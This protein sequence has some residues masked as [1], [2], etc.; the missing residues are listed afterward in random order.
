MGE[1]REEGGSGADV[2]KSDQRPAPE[3]PPDSCS[4]TPQTDTGESVQSVVVL[5]TGCSGGGASITQNATPHAHIH[6]CDR[7][8]HTHSK[9]VRYVSE[10][11]CQYL[12]GC[13]SVRSTTPSCPLPSVWAS[14]LHNSL[15]FSVSGWPQ[16]IHCFTAHTRDGS[17]WRSTALYNSF[18]PHKDFLLLVLDAFTV[19]FFSSRLVFFVFV[20]P[21]R[22]QN[23]ISA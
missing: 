23:T 10:H 14:A 1:A 18:R 13:A 21:A 19:Y 9:A 8:K 7:H 3:F 15:F 17:Q 6:T 16:V 4:E 20:L 22:T 5:H 12:Q 11:V 2:E